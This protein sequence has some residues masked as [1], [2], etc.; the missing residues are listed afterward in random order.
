MSLAA[1]FSYAIFELFPN[2]TSKSSNSSIAFQSMFKRVMFL[3]FKLVNEN[4]RSNFVITPKLI[5]DRAD[6]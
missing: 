2:T 3:H 1:G 5:T 6:E 4:L